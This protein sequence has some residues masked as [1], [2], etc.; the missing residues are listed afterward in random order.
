CTISHFTVRPWRLRRVTG[1]S[2]RDCWAE[3]TRS[4]NGRLGR[5][6]AAF[7]PTTAV[8]AAWAPRATTFWFALDAMRSRWMGRAAPS[9]AP[10]A[11]RRMSNSLTYSSL[12]GRIARLVSLPRRSEAL[13]LTGE[14]ESLME[15][16]ANLALEVTVADA[17]KQ[18]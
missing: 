15:I 18:C 7:T 11:A 12:T 17:R 13:R 4:T 2:S 16:T 10:S 3:N 5:N 8:G 1:T 14:L 6:V 9:I